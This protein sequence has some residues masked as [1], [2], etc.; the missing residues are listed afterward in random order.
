M[1]V[2]ANRGLTL[3]EVL[4][5]L[6]VLMLGLLG[7]SGL[8]IK[9]S[10]L[11]YE[12]YQRQQALAVASD[13]AERMRANQSPALASAANLATADVYAKAAPSLLPLGDPSKATMWTGLTN[14]TV[15]DCA[16]VATCT[17]EQ[18]AR[19]DLAL[20]EGQLLG[21]G[22]RSGGDSVGGISNARG[23]VEGP[24]ADLSLNVAAPANTYRITVAWQGDSP[25][26]VSKTQ[27]E[28]LRNVATCA[29]NLYLTR[30][31]DPDL[32]DQYRRLVV[33]YQV[34]N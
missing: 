9:A 11:N 7:L 12:A 5:T 34:I 31:R 25:V 6:V 13:M 19:Y 3:I 18:I 33:L 1:S 17:P 15:A 16:N 29:K 26:P 14:K 8:I 10:R 23:C 4:V 32:D 28:D 2:K 27:D 24:V 30:D 20:W 21:A 22:R